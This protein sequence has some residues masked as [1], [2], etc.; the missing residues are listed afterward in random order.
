MVPRRRALGGHEVGSP[1]DLDAVQADLERLALPAETTR[2]AFGAEPSADT[3][4]RTYE[5]DSIRDLGRSPPDGAEPSF[6][7]AL[8]EGTVAR[9]RAL[10]PGRALITGAP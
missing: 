2:P 5:L 3:E 4:R 10:R 7:R 6:S 9:S 8:G 1:A